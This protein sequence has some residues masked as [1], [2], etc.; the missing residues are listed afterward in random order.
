MYVVSLLPSGEQFEGFLEVLDGR[1]D[2]LVL[3]GAA[4]VLA[5]LLGPRE[6]LRTET[7]LTWRDRER[8]IEILTIYLDLGAH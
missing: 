6:V 2:V 7:H 4:G 5:V 1:G 3:Q 8:E